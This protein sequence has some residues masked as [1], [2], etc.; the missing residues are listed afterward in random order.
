MPRL[1]LLP[2]AFAGDEGLPGVSSGGRDQLVGPAPCAHPPAGGQR[3]PAHVGL[4]HRDRLRHV[5]K[6][7]TPM[8]YLQRVGY[9]TE[10]HSHRTSV[11]C[12]RG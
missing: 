10:I 8:P 5:H 6:G 2:L 11:N 12:R 7:D 1:F 9:V 4:L 3:L